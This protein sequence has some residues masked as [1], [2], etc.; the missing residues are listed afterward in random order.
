MSRRRVDENCRS[1]REHG[2][3]AWVFE[4]GLLVFEKFRILLMLEVVRV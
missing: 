4:N 2:S 3:V 1:T